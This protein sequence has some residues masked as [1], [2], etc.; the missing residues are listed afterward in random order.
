MPNPNPKRYTRV[1]SVPL[2]DKQ[3]ARLDALVTAGTTRSDLIRA[4]IDA[5]LSDESLSLA[6]P[7][8]GLS[9]EDVER[10]MERVLARHADGIGGL[11]KPSP[12]PQATPARR[13]RT[14][15]AAAGSLDD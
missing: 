15:R 3:A 2:T 5:Y 14:S 6:K 9:V 7:S 11:S 12:A 1:V 8:A 4:A 10:A 13:L